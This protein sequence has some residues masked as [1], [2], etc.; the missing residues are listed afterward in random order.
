MSGESKRSQASR[1]PMTPLRRTFGARFE[2]TL[3]WTSR[4]MRR[5]ISG[6]SS[7][8]RTS[9]TF[10]CDLDKDDDTEIN[11]LHLC[12]H[13]FSIIQ[14]L[15]SFFAA[16]THRW[17]VLTSRLQTKKLLVL[18][19]LIDTR[20][21]AHK[22][23]THAVSEG[24]TE[25]IM[26]L[27]DIAEDETE[28]KNAVAEANGL[29]KKME[30]LEFAIFSRLWNDILTR[31]N[32]VSKFVQAADADI[33]TI[34]SL[35]SSLKS[36]VQSLRDDF[37]RYE[38]EGKKIA[39]D[40]VF[41]DEQRRPRVRSSRVTKNEGNA[42]DTIPKGS[43]KFRVEVFIP[44]LD[45][46]STC[47]QQ[48]F[49]AYETINNRFAFIEKLPDLTTAQIKEHCKVVSCYYDKDLEH[50]Q[51]YLECLQFVDYV[52]EERQRLLLEKES[53]ER[54]KETENNTDQSPTSLMANLYLNIKTDNLMLS[55]PHIEILLR[56]FLCMMVTNCTGERS[57][58]KLKLIKSALRAAMLQRRLNSLSI[59]SIE[60]DLINQHQIQS[61]KM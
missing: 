31:F 10:T 55:F 16:S 24:Y 39:P 19:R 17:G 58:S 27:T 40:A 56:I 34:N 51:L 54:Q 14:R 61:P 12:T 60:S 50:R 8:V 35:I 46:L 47:L 26:A 45:S 2:Y 13:F 5:R 42:E 9:T 4:R 37:D 7:T 3:S 32:R 59:L 25:I 38:Q 28:E 29:K 30:S 23:A 43:N 1:G 48:R 20:W 41:V 44:I 33:S 11:K 36:F 6:V 21:S 49:I 15:Y 22:D 53:K 57:F 18:K 52:S